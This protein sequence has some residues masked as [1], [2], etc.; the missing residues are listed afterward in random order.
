MTN[1][2]KRLNN[3]GLFFK[4]FFV[5]IISIVIVS[6]AI[7][8]SSLRMSE[9]LFLDT[10]SITNSKIINQIKEDLESFHFS[11]VMTSNNIIKNGTINS[12]FTEQDSHSLDMYKSYY[13]MHEQMNQIATTLDS[14]DVGITI[15]GNNGRHY[16]TNRNYWSRLISEL[17][18]HPITLHSL[19]HPQQLT[20]HLDQQK[21]DTDV[22]LNTIIASR[23]LKNISSENISG[24][25]Y[26]TFFESN[27]RKFYNN[28]ISNGNDVIF[29]NHSGTIISSNQEDLIGKKEKSLLKHA[30]HINQQTLES[31]M[32]KFLGS[33]KIMISEYIPTYEMYIINLIDQ[34]KMMENIID[35]QKI[36][37][38]SFSIVLIAVFLLFIIFRQLTK[39]LRNFIKQI[40]DM[41]KYDFDHYVTASG[42]YETKQ[43]STAF[44]YMLDELHNYVDQ[45][46][47]TQ[48]KQRNAEL[49]ALQQQI[50]PHF[51]YNTLASIKF[52]VKQ[53]NKKNAT[54]MINKLIS[55]LQNV[56]GNVDETNTV[57]QELKNIKNYVFINQ[58]R[59]GE[60]IR[61]QYFITP[62]CLLYKIPKL[63]IQPFIENSFFHAFNQKKSGYIHI[64]ISQQRDSL[65]IEI[66]D[67]GDGMKITQEETF[68]SSQ[69]NYQS[70]T[71]IGIKNV[72]ERIKLLYGSPYG[73]DMTSTLGKGTKV[74]V[75]L[76]IIKSKNNINT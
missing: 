53:G 58:M 37:F 11:I 55:L 13:Q 43:L 71:G 4:V 60:K 5:M 32:I 28:Y 47:E 27:F 9:K 30:K 3:Y 26:M 12:F 52:M 10:F 63:I 76:P 68:N 19:D 22:T 17:P 29:M 34:Q 65:I 38:I 20:Y 25:I 7:T 57:E 44:N 61:V 66:I 49:T 73:I 31:D 1:L 8:L 70:F 59:Y 42:S 21:D 2:L 50:N 45:L 14:Y 54:N 74:Q 15:I 48:K 72:H 24:V 69:D 51:L 40:S 18:E 64:M 35:P 6:I 62:D 36:I 46:M 23:T 16:S 56:L 67:N 41:P 33:E 75:H 39:S